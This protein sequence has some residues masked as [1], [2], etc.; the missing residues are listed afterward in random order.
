MRALFPLACMTATVM[1]L[2]AC[3]PRFSEVREELREH[4]YPRDFRFLERDE[5]RGVMARLAAEVSE[6]DRVL[7][8]HAE[9]QP[10]RTA[11]LLGEMRAQLT[12]LGNGGWPSNHPGFATDAEQLTREVERALRHVQRAPPDYFWAGT[13]SAACL[14]CH[15]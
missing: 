1:V 13:V 2:T 12:S 5:I 15:N 10:E 11:K 3:G 7:S 8:T 9:P 6:L 14:R 4:T